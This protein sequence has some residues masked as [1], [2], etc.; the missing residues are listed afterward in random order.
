MKK[1]ILILLISAFVCISTLHAKSISISTD[2][3]F[4][5][6]FSFEEDGLSKGLH[7]DIVKYALANIGYKVDLSP[8]PW[9]RCLIEAEY[10]ET[11]AIISA[12]YKPERAN[13]MYYPSDAAQTKISKWRI[14]Q[15]EYVIVGYIKDPYEFK[16]DVKSLPNPVRAP[17]SYSVIDD[18]NKA[19]IKVESAK[20]DHQNL[21]KLLRSKKGVVVTLPEII[22]LLKTSNPEFSENFKVHSVPFKS[23]SYFLSF[24]Q[25]GNISSGERQK[26]WDAIRKVRESDEVMGK[27]ITKYR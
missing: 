19:G 3:N 20:E 9:K 7:I 8:R 2:D 15:V 1:L 24:S 17:S 4:W 26:I 22:H 21:K 25:K 27:L 13:Y 10:G 18:L 5:Y 23:K 12:S 6:P 14:T 16:G 11:D